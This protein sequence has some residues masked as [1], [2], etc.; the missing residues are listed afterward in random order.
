VPGAPNFAAAGVSIIGKSAAPISLLATET[1]KEA[2]ATTT[3]SDEPAK[4]EGKVIAIV[5][6]IAITRIEPEIH[7]LF[8]AF[9]FSILSLTLPDVTPV[10]PR[11]VSDISH[12]TQVKKISPE[13]LGLGGNVQ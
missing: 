5:S 12:L 10:T 4:F 13:T 2:S 11:W 6:P 8:G 1:S 3:G 9:S 7:R